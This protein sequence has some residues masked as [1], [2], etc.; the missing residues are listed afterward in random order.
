MPS[1][2]PKPTVSP[3]VLRP[4]VSPE[5]GAPSL[6]TTDWRTMKATIPIQ[7][8]SSAFSKVF[9]FALVPKC[10]NFRPMEDNRNLYKLAIVIGLVLILVGIYQVEERSQRHSKLTIELNR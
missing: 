2:T 1:P 10:Y 7:Q 6:E 5:S 3:A 4:S 8:Y 9:M